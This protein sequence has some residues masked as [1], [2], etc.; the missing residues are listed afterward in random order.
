MALTA[1]VVVQAMPKPF[2]D[3]NPGPEALAKP[4]ALANPEALAAPE[5][6]AYADP[7]WRRGGRHRG[8]HGHGRNRG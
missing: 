3:P 4:E 7:H 6:L 1:L 5:A 8:G 2:P